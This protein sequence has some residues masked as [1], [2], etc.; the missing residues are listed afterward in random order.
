MKMTV[1]KMKDNPVTKAIP[2]IIPGYIP[3][4]DGRSIFHTEP[5]TWGMPDYRV[6]YF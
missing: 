6:Y 5:A 1:P 4:G 3:S 2:A